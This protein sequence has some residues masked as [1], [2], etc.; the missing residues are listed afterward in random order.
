MSWV[1]FTA[2]H[3]HAGLTEPEVTHYST[4]LLVS[5]QAD[6]LGEIVSQTAL[7]FREAIRSHP[8]HS[9]HADP[10]YLP[11]GA[12]MHASAVARYRLLTRIGD[13]IGEDRRAEYREAMRYLDKV[14]KGDRYVEDPDGTESGKSPSPTP[15][16]TG[17]DKTY[18]R[19]NQDGI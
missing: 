11:Q 3:V 19:T 1:A 5:G 13:E 16:I 9:L 14:A 2:S 15:Y 10:T 4:K 18:G 8:D 12:I 17:R 7:E 6:P